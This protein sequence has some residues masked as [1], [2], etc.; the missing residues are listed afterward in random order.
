MCGVFLLSTSFLLSEQRR[1]LIRFTAFLVFH[2]PHTVQV[3]STITGRS[4]LE[5]TYEQDVTLGQ[6]KKLLRGTHQNNTKQ[7]RLS[8]EGLRPLSDALIIG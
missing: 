6:L 5:G 8:V 2:T 3:R 7:A 4:L 1:R